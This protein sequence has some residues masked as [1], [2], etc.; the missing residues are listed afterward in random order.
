MVTDNTGAAF[1]ERMYYPYGQSW[2]TAGAWVR[3]EFGAFRDSVL[4]GDEVYVTPFRHYRTDVYRWLS[5]DPLAG[6]V[7]NPQSLN[8]YAYVLNNPVNLIDPLGL[9]D[10]GQQHDPCDRNPNSPACT[11]QPR[12]N[13]AISSDMSCRMDGVPINCTVIP[14]VLNA[15]LAAVCPNN[16][17][18]GLRAT[19]GPGGS[20]VWQQWVPGG[21]S[22][23]PSGVPGV[24][25]LMTTTPGHW[26]IV[27]RNPDFYQFTVN[28][29]GA[30]G[31]TFTLTGDTNGNVYVA[32]LGGN[33]GKSLL[34]FS[35]S[36]TGGWMSGY[37][38]PEPPPPPVLK[39]FLSGWGCS[40]GGGAVF[41]VFGHSSLSGAGEGRSEGVV[42][43]QGGVSCGYSI[44]LFSLF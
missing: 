28:I 29:G 19:Q 1:G 30:V 6:D 15:G 20:T 35:F 40:A 39:D 3:Q 7:M 34:G 16:D 36:L 13:D 33:V 10:G 5:P 38:R 26:E 4:G 2:R 44:R 22:I 12:F 32:P 24:D 27:G 31:Y 18:T 21:Y 17:C 9:Q 41:G 43:P 8:R 14:R 37:E 23:Q 11:G 42:W 25:F